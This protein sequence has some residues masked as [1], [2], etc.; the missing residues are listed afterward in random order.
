M[1][2]KLHSYPKVW[3]LG[4]RAIKDLFAGPV[5]VQEKLDGSQ[6]S[7]GIF[8]GELLMRSRG[9]Y[10]F[11][12]AVDNLFKPAVETV[13]RLA[14]A[15]ALMPGWTYRAEAICKP[16]HNTLAYGRAPRGGMV[17]FDIDVELEGRIADPAQLA[18]IGAELGL[19]VTPTVYAGTVTSPLQLEEFLKRESMLGA[20]TLEGIVIKNY[21]RFGEDGKQLIGKWVREEFKELNSGDFKSR[22]PTRSDV[23]QAIIAEY[24][25]EQRWTKAVQR[26]R[27]LGQLE[28]SPRDIG[29]IIAEIPEDVI[30]E[31]EDDIKQKLFD[32]AWQ[33]IRRGIVAGVAEWY[34]LQ[35]AQQQEY[36]TAEE[37][38]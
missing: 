25:N 22:N 6:F 32:R 26:L 16:K 5:V 1:S 15:G 34:K 3:S 14:D 31:C 8:D 12:D 20:V 38:A 11:V 10:I 7:F 30:A 37:T 19:E 27:D 24:R 28:G 18:A 29:K 36:A 17:L 13:T 21:S 9:A 2:N 35:L 4:H 23:I 33:D